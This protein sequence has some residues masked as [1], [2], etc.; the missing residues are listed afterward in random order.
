MDYQK[1]PESEAQRAKRLAQGDSTHKRVSPPQIC[2]KDEIIYNRVSA[3]ARGPLLIL[4]HGAL[5]A[6]LFPLVRTSS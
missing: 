6:I 1:N 4:Q 2:K 5:K 3:G